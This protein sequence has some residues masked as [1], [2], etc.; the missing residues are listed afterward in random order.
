MIYVPI[1]ERDIVPVV[2]VVVEVEL[3]ESGRRYARAGMD[4]ALQTAVAPLNSRFS[5]P[6]S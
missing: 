6:A 3:S 2:G 5:D 1:D 4:I